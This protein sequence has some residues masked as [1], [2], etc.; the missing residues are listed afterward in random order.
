M[1]GR[2]CPFPGPWPLSRDPGRGKRQLWAY[3]RPARCK[4]AA[5]KALVYHGPGQKAWEDVPDPVIQRRHRRDRPG[6]HGDHLRHRPAHPQGRRPGGQPAAASWATRRSAPSSRSAPASRRSAGRPGAGLVHLGVRAVPVLPG[7]PLR[8]VPGRR[9]LD[10]R[11]PDRRH[12]GRVR[13]GPVRRHLDLPGPGR[14]RRRGDPDARRHPAD[15]LRGRR[16][17]RPGA[18]GRHRRRRR[19]RPDRAVGD[20]RRRAVLARPGSSRST[21]PTPGWRRPSSSVPT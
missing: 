21:W 3:V 20:H 16:A 10:P 14:R 1:P 9:R 8:P 12:A 2:P 4:E 17:Q 7:G 18:A 5:M 11:A 15:R 19:R 6:R 13:P